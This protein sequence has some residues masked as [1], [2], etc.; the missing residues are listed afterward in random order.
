M[1][2]WRERHEEKKKKVEMNLFFE[3]VDIKTMRQVALMG[4]YLTHS[5]PVYGISLIILYNLSKADDVLNY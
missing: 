3:K 2:R 1:H 4:R 5:C